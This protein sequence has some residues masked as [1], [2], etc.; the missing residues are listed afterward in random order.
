MR[1]SHNKARGGN[2]SS[3]PLDL[4]Q[5]RLFLYITVIRETVKAN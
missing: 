2:T 4:N 1:P 5:E 3:E